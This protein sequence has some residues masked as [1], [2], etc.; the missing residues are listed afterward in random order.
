M[1]G[2]L[3]VACGVVATPVVTGAD[4]APQA[5]IATVKAKVRRNMMV[6][7][8]ARS[9]VPCCKLAAMKAF[10]F[11]ALLFVGC[12]ETA[13]ATDAAASASATT[14][15]APPR[16]E[17]DSHGKWWAI[18][19]KS[20]VYTNDRRIDADNAIRML[21]EA[22]RIKV[23]RALDDMATQTHDADGLRA[24]SQIARDGQ[25]AVEDVHNPAAKNALTSAAWVVLHGLVST[26]C[27][28]HTDKPALDD[29]IAEIREMPLPH[30]DKGTGINERDI[31]LQ[32]MKASVADE[33]MMKA[34]LASA[35]PPKK[36]I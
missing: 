22:A 6:R 34:V 31:L 25:D 30:L 29:L 20:H 23:R 11:L 18:A 3:A 5:A 26:V 35:P 1:G 10:V 8:S 36:S 17:F 14:S 13:S 2:V 27:A 16:V 4:G 24:A 7:R 32:E 19:Q 33:K 9:I 21:P 28:E 15:A 12:K